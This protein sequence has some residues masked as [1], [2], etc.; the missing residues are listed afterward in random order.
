MYLLLLYIPI[1]EIP[2]VLLELN[3]S[4]LAYITREQFDKAMLLLQKAHGVLDHVDISSSKR[5]QMI[6]I[7]IF[8]NMALCYQKQGQLEECAL[9]LETCLEHFGSDYIDLRNKSIAMRLIKLK[10]ECKVRMQLCA[11]LS[12]L[13]RHKE[14]LDQAYESAKICNIVVSDQVAICEFL[15][16][17]LN[18]EN[19][20]VLAQK[21]RDNANQ[22]HTNQEES[23]AAIVMDN[24][25]QFSED[26]DADQFDD[27]ST[28]SIGKFQ[29]Y[30]GFINNLEDSIS[31]VEKTAK[32][33]M[34]IF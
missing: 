27:C 32:K 2:I 24:Y 8:Y 19:V 23:G 4:A 22:S 18:F 14:A 33:L 5:D 9:C 28:D 6:A 7:E 25:S 31:L 30:Q 26:A 12:Q 15:S 17:R 1:D 20:N 10:L 3:E 16:K 13:H 29:T 11:I 34:P 21:Q